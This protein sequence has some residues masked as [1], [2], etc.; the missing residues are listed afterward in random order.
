MKKI[1]TKYFY[2][3]Q[4]FWEIL[5]NNSF[6]YFTFFEGMSNLEALKT[7]RDETC[8][9]IESNILSYWIKKA[10]DPK[11][12]FYGQITGHNVLVPDAV[13][14]GILNA[15]ILWTFSAAYS[16]CTFAILRKQNVAKLWQKHAKI[17]QKWLYKILKYPICLVNKKKL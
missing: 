1:Y 2:I 8:H 13:K 12:G 3:F 10:V 6:F 7:L 16:V 14:G 4:I 9:E 5:K 11:G 15:R 17:A